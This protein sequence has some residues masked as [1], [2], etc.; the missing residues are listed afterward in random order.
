M[1]STL[2]HR[3]PA[4]IWGFYHRVFSYFKTDWP[5][6]TVLYG[7]II[8][9]AALD[10]FLPIPLAVLFDNV[11]AKRAIEEGLYKRIY[12]F[13]LYHLPAS[14][15]PKIICLITLMILIKA[16]KDTL[17][18]FRGMLNNRIRYNGTTRVRTQLYNK[19]Q[20]LEIF[21]HKSVSSGDAIY[22]MTTDAWGPFGVLDNFIGSSAAIL[23]LVSTFI[24]MYIWNRQLTIFMMQLLPV[25][26]LLLIGTNFWFSTK[27]RQYSALTKRLEMNF[28]M[29][30]Q[31][32]MNAMGL[33]QSF[34]RQSMESSK[35]QAANAAS[36]KAAIKLNWQENLHP[37][38]IDTL[39]TMGQAGISGYGGYLVY[40]ARLD[41]GLLT[42]FILNYFGQVWA[43]L[44]W[45]IG[46]VARVQVH[47]AASERV[48]TVLDYP[49][50]IMEDPQALDISVKPRVLTIKDASFQYSKQDK[51][52]L[53]QISLKINPGEMVAI[54]GRSGA[55]KS[56]FLSLLGRFYDPTSG[57]VFLD[58]YQLQKISL[59]RLRQHMAW[60][61]QDSTLLPVTISEN[62]SYGNPT[63][64]AEQIREAATLAGAAEF[65]EDLPDGYQTCVGEGGQNFSGG[66]RQ[67]IAIARAL[68]TQAPIL[69][70]D[71][72][73]SALDPGHEEHFLETLSHLKRKRTI[74]LVTHRIP[75]T[76]YCDKTFI[77]KNGKMQQQTLP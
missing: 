32:A 71:E 29:V 43:H 4:K 51:P 17:V 66:Q 54:L 53:S 14:V 27:I 35:V 11:L 38:T 62:I 60:V 40:Q 76:V 25:L 3:S 20:S 24:M 65:I 19:L 2:Y 28:T 75:I 10:L 48:F 36:L 26:V 8:S 12:Q 7:M 23:S 69:I 1:A 34:G 72:P 39:F 37:W 49:I 67:R 59:S 30:V 46:F 41:L 5:L 77:I 58:E 13:L 64:T 52:V 15:I 68:V 70:F 73:T 57:S 42:A 33:I 63:A 16:L 22:R 6:I 56:T 61:T 21:Y 31:R 18:M 50:S 44:T 55:G 47:S 9:C 74:I 45:L